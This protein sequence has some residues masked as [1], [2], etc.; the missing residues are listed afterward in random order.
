MWKLDVGREWKVDYVRIVCGLLSGPAPIHVIKRGKTCNV[1]LARRTVGQWDRETDRRTDCVRQSDQL[2]GWQNRIPCQMHSDKLFP[3]TSG[4]YTHKRSSALLVSLQVLP[5]TL[6][7]R[8]QTEYV[9]MAVV[10]F[11]VVDNVVLDWMWISL[12]LWIWTRSWR[13]LDKSL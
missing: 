1:P 8:Q 2:N 6:R 5:A 11:V 10:V 3:D 13:Q 9:D 12:G 4:K 7:Q